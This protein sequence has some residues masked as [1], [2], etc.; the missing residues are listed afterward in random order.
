MLRKGERHVRQAKV[1]ASSGGW[2]YAIGTSQYS[3]SDESSHAK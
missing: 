1:E 2:T 3:K